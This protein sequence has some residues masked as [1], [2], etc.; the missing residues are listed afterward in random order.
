MIEEFCPEAEQASIQI[1]AFDCSE[2]V[3][4]DAPSNL[5]ASAFYA[6]AVSEGF[7]LFPSPAGG[8]VHRLRV[9]RSLPQIYGSRFTILGT[10]AGR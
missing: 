8:E 6:K 5:S 4:L 1:K 3:F 9:R 2:R 10:R 7:F